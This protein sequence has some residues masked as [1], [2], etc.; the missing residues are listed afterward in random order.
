MSR[1]PEIRIRNW[2]KFQHY[3]KRNPPW[4]RLYRDLVDNPEWRQTS[5]S[6]ARL[7]VELW[8]LASETDPGG[9]IPF[10][11][12]LLAWRTGRASTDAS[13]IRADLKELD[14]QGFIVLPSTDASTDASTSTPQRQSTENIS[15]SNE[16][17]SKPENAPVSDM[18]DLWLD[19]FGGSGRQ[20][21]LTANRSKALTMLYREQLADEDDPLAMFGKVLDAV[22]RSEHHMSKR[23]YQYPDSLFRNEDRRDRW[24]VAAASPNGKG[25]HWAT[26]L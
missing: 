11:I 14:T 22:A 16:D 3:K 9:R 10:D 25:D 18:W 21:T 20:P 24:V 13:K 26:S 23:E 1:P 7:L 15:S 8:L 4:I 19:R 17:S 6:A 12:N 5:D 2:E